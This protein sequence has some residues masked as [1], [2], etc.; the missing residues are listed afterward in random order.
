MHSNKVYVGTLAARFAQWSVNR[1]RG[2]SQ[3]LNCLKFKIYFIKELFPT[4]LSGANA[5]LFWLISVPNEKKR[6]NCICVEIQIFG[7]NAQSKW[8]ARQKRLQI[9]NYR[10][11]KTRTL[12]SDFPSSEKQILSLRIHFNYYPPC[13]TSRL[14]PSWDSQIASPERAKLLWT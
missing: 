5:V 3:F 8:N 6:L 12:L 7:W 14:M 9:F 1:Y 4:K 10:L 11:G 2:H 13:W